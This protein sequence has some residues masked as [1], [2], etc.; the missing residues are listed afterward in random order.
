MERAHVG[1]L[2]L[3]ALEQST[4]ALSGPWVTLDLLPGPIS[5]D[6]FLSFNY[7]YGTP[8]TGSILAVCWEP[9][10]SK[11]INSRR[12]ASQ[13]A[14]YLPPTVDHEDL[15]VTRFA[16]ISPPTAHATVQAYMVTIGMA[17]SF[18]TAHT[19]IR[20][21]WDHVFASAQQRY[22]GSKMGLYTAFSLL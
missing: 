17:D 18:A 20:L 7:V 10:P 1:Q 14:T 16:L 5:S 6:T 15:E 4:A 21:P 22:Y 13:W 12:A 19:H 8:A 3:Q 11:R 2:A 9:V